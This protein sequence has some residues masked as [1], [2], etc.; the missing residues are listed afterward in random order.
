M[1]HAQRQTGALC[2]P[3][4]GVAGGKRAPVQQQMLRHGEQR[5]HLSRGRQAL[6]AR[7]GMYSEAASAQEAGGD[8][9]SCRAR[10]HAADVHLLV[11][12]QAGRQREATCMCMGQPAEGSCWHGEG[13]HL[14]AAPCLPAWV[15]WPG[16]N[17]S[18]DCLSHVTPC[19]RRLQPHARHCTPGFENLPA[20]RPDKQGLPEMLPLCTGKLSRPEVLCG[21]IFSR[22]T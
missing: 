16:M 10:P 4:R 14:H 22:P 19:N 1:K 20:T 12:K 8:L 17:G 11:D 13:A 15:L 7:R 2:R 18:I 6:L 21:S 5:R 9:L 3:S